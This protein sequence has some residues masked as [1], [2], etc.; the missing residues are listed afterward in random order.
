[1]KSNGVGASLLRC[2]T[3]V[4]SMKSKKGFLN[5]STTVKKPLLTCLATMNDIHSLRDCEG[6]MA[7]KT[8]EVTEQYKMERKWEGVRV[9]E[10]ML[11]KKRD[12]S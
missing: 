9:R 1:M 10:Q 8:N 7:K 4:T 2:S 3:A 12:Y 5:C 11:E 6:Q